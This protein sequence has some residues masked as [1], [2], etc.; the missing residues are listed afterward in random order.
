MFSLPK[1]PY[2][3]ISS[4]IDFKSWLGSGNNISSS[5]VTATDDAGA[6]VTSTVIDSSIFS[7]T[8]VYYTVKAGVDASAYAIS[9]KIVAD[10]GQKFKADVEM[11]VQEEDY[12]DLSTNV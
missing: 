1:Q 11:M 7:G 2:E 10:D 4:S 5:T 3:K 9:A 12:N 6:D 8:K